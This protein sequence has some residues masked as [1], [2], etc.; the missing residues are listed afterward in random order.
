M[1]RRAWLGLLLCG[2]A[3]GASA[4]G[5]THRFAVIGHSFASKGGE[6][7]LEQA[8]GSARDSDIAFIVATGIKGAHEPCTD[9]VYSKRRELFDEARRP[10]I[11]VPAASDWTG[12][13]NSSGRDV[14][15]ER[16]N[17]LRELFYPDDFSRGARQIELTRLSNTAKFRSYAED[18][19]WVVGKVLYATLNLP[20]NNNHYLNEAGR[21]NE[22]EDR[23][24]AHRF[25][26]K[27]V[28]TLA[29]RMHVEAVVLFSEGDLKAL[30]DKPGLLSMLRRPSSTA[31]DGFAET[32][33]LVTSLAQKFNGKVLLVDAAVPPAGAKPALVWRANLGH[34]SVGSETLQVDVTPGTAQLF[35]LAEKDGK[36]GNEKDEKDKGS[37]RHEKA[38]KSARK[39]PTN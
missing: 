26:I 37:G 39:G 21:N 10:V 23:M 7:R 1:M 30:A 15:L 14:P 36:D 18:A 34:L 27:R 6:E 32:R 33:K 22:F 4:A 9:A 17:R 20:S 38:V 11:V 2:L 35:A 5:T 3:L 31:Q 19:H 13:V 28:F 12:C 24:V 8:L 25:W 29:R 16:L